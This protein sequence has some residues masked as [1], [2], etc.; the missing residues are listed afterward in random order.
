MAVS[1]IALLGISDDISTGN[2]IVDIIIAILLIPGTFISGLFG[3]FGGT[4]WEI[5]GMLIT[6]TLTVYLIEKH[7]KQ[8]PDLNDK[9]N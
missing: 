6:I 9:A 5:I 4:D 2:Y 1:F 7:F 3:F 8:P